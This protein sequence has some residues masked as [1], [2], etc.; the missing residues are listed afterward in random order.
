M[1]SPVVGMRLAKPVRTNQAASTSGSGGFFIPPSLPR[2]SQ[3]AGSLTMPRIYHSSLARRS[4]G[5]SAAG[6]A[7][8]SRPRGRGPARRGRSPSGPPL[9]QRVQPA[10]PAVGCAVSQEDCV[11]SLT[12]LRSRLCIVFRLMTGEHLGNSGIQD[13]PLPLQSDE[14]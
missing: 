6:S 12:S 4:S 13:E 11:R 5:I 3:T 8:A 14:C 7:K 10:Q 1:P 2:Q 9:A